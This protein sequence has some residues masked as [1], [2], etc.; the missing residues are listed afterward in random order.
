MQDVAG[1]PR[2]CHVDHLRGPRAQ[3]LIV[4]NRAFIKLPDASQGSAAAEAKGFSMRTRRPLEPLSSTP[5]L[6]PD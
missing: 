5:E 4:Q 6:A 1:V 3:K 2:A